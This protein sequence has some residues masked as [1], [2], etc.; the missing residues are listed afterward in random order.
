MQM[1]FNV[2]K[3]AVEVNVND[4]VFTV[5]KGGIWQ[6]PR[7]K[8]LPLFPCFPVTLFWIF[9]RTPVSF[10]FRFHGDGNARHS[11]ITRPIARLHLC[12]TV[13]SLCLSPGGFTK[14]DTAYVCY[15]LSFYA[16]SRCVI[17]FP[18]THGSEGRTAGASERAVLWLVSA[19]AQLHSLHAV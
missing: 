5:H 10:S 18:T 15:P 9:S 3:G 14:R 12:T 19:G 17:T 11:I 1:V 8:W 16:L 13:V 6:V 7:G 4:N 2:M